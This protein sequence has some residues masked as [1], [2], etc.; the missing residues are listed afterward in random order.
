MKKSIWKR[1]T[2]A[3]WSSKADSEIVKQYILCW[4]CYFDS[5]PV[6]LPFSCFPFDEFRLHLV[7]DP[8][9][10]SSVS[11]FFSLYFSLL[12]FPLC[13]PFPVRTHH[14]IPLLSSLPPCQRSRL[15]HSADESGLREL[16]H[17]AALCPAGEQD[18][19]A[20]APTRRAH[21][22]GRGCGGCE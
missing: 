18:P 6:F 10:N 15:W 22:S 2:L 5:V 17:T 20:L 11:K 9:M 21:R 3:S 8:A 12:F 7:T 1:S 4:W 19:A 13:F 14:F 16:R